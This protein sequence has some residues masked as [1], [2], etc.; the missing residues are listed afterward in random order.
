M[1]YD[2]F[3]VPTTTKEEWL[4]SEQVRGDSALIAST[5]VE[6]NHQSLSS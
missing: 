2:A 1:G 5:A 4:S 6:W 3:G